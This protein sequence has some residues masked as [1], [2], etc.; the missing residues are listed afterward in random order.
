MLPLD[1]E[2]IDFLSCLLHYV[3]SVSK[4]LTTDYNDLVMVV[5]NLSVIVSRYVSIISMV[6]SQSCEERRC[7][8]K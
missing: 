5:V 6:V 7:E 2:R 1:V 8:E 4:V 3:R